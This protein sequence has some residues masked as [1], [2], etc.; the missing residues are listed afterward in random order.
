M[1][2]FGRINLFGFLALCGTLLL[3]LYFALREWFSR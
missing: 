2:H 1:R 3:T